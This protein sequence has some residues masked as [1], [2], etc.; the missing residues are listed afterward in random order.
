MSY[1]FIL[2]KFEILDRVDKR[3]Q[4]KKKMLKAI[5]IDILVQNL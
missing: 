5:T 2:G 4:K 3:E 1:K